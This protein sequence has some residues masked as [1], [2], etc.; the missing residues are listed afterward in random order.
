MRI[1]WEVLLSYWR[2]EEEDAT[3]D[4]EEDSGP[5]DSDSEDD[6]WMKSYGRGIH[7]QEARRRTQRTS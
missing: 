4:E 1:A 7:G 2:T 6:A 3:E 5:G